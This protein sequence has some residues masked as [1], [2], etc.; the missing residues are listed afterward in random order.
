MKLN[1][2]FSLTMAREKP[3]M[4][5]EIQKGK[6]SRALSLLEQG[7]C[8]PNELDPLY[9]WTPLHI[10]AREN[11]L[12][13][14]KSLLDH[15]ANVDVK[16]KVGQT[17]LHRAC[18]W[19]NR[20]MVQLL[21][22]HAADFTAFDNLM[23]TPEDL[24]KQQG[25]KELAEHLQDLHSTLHLHLDGHHLTHYSKEK[26]AKMEANLKIKKQEEEKRKSF[27]R[28]LEHNTKVMEKSKA[29]ETKFKEKRQLLEEKAEGYKAEIQT[30][31][32][33]SGSGLTKEQVARLKKLQIKVK[34]V[35]FE[36]ENQTVRSQR[37]MSLVS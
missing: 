35:L 34:N 33:E 25:H 23:Q 1:R 2:S 19:G 31:V 13:L 9:M 36:L 15:G 14:A 29:L 20:D 4:I 6:V 27:R 12:E 5:E 37:R 16:D 30:L 32:N 3:S 22:D 18:Y 24:A 26:I 7:I 21:L 8:Y 11:K 10:A 17:P 28:T